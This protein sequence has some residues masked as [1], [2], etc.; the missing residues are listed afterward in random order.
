[1]LMMAIAT[2]IL[3]IVGWLYFRTKPSSQK[4][5]DSA[6]LSKSQQ[7]KGSKDSKNEGTATSQDVE[8]DTKAGKKVQQG[9]A[10]KPKNKVDHRFFFKSFKKNESSVL[11]FDISRDNQFIGI[12]SKDRSH[13]IYDIRHDS[14]VKFSTSRQSSFRHHTAVYSSLR[15]RSVRCSG[16]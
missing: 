11:D 2:T 10:K 12:A 1:M 5:F 4:K 16:S 7:R 9:V 13:V 15:A 8:K 14:V 6:Y 3:I